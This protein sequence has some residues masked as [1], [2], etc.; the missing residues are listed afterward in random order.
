MCL[1]PSYKMMILVPEAPAPGASKMHPKPEVGAAQ[2]QPLP[3]AD[4]P[5]WASLLPWA[6]RRRRASRAS[7]RADA[8]GASVH[9]LSGEGVRGVSA[10]YA[11]R[12]ETGPLST[13]G[14]DETCPPQGAL[15]GGAGG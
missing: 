5:R 9:V 14:R 2:P 11:G 13:G 1:K 4:A 10:Q 6:S 3:G 7:A 12:D 8:V 15:C